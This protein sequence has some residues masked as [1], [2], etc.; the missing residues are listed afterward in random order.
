MLATLGRHDVR[1]GLATSRPEVFARR[2]LQHFALIDYFTYVGGASLDASRIEKADVRAYALP[3]RLREGSILVGDRAADV[4]G[5]RAHNMSCIGVLWGYGSR[6][7]LHS[8]GAVNLIE[9]PNDLIRDL[10][11][12]I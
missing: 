1:I 7:K 12:Q 3:K 5:A 2:I 8:A 6:D 10:A 4:T 11:V 9:H